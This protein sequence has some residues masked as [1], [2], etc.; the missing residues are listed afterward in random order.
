MRHG[1]HLTALTDLG[2]GGGDVPRTAEVAAVVVVVV[3]H[4][5]LRD[6]KVRSRGGGGVRGDGPVL[7]HAAVLHD[8]V[9]LQSCMAIIS[10]HTS[11]IHAFIHS[12]IHQR[13][14]LTP[15]ARNVSASSISDT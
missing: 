4:Q 13:T 8:V 10:E 5:V 1:V 11:N 9:H 12:F 14:S 2:Y 3:A 6:S 15:Q 7:L